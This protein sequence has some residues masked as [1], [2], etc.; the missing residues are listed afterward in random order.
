MYNIGNYIRLAAYKY[1]AL[2]NYTSYLDPKQSQYYIQFEAKNLSRLFLITV[3]CCMP[4]YVYGIFKDVCNMMPEIQIFRF[5]I[6]FEI[7]CAFAWIYA[8]SLTEITSVLFMKILYVQ[9]ILDEIELIFQFTTYILKIKGE[10]KYA[11]ELIFLNQQNL[12]L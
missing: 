10:V 4:L 12:L 8:P 2:H 6:C 9:T 7:I 5:C 3:F 11:G 1:N